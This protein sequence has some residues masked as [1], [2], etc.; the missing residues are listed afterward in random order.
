M[1]V[2]KANGKKEKFNFSKI[3]RTGIR[4]GVPKIDA[5]KIAKAVE[6]EAY[7]G[8]TTKEVLDM[9][10]AALDEKR[11]GY[12]SKYDL[13]GAIMRLG[14]SGFPFEKLVA[15]MFE[16]LGYSAVTDVIVRG[17]CVPHEVDVIAEKEG[18]R[19][20]IECKYRNFPGVYIGLQKALYVWARYEDLQA[21][22][23]MKKCE[24]FDVPY[25]ICN[26]R[27]SEQAMQYAS[28][29]GLKLKGWNYP[30]RESISDILTK[31]KIY[32]VTVLRSVNARTLQ[33]LS[34]ARM[35]LCDDLIEKKLIKTGISRNRAKRIMNEVAGVL[36]NN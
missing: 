10:L 18:M 3:V 31:N 13:K 21:G 26:T 33:L 12:A 20:M 6:E 8:I 29:I 23:K 11:V 32:P 19:A 28:C 30:P 16:R 25:L 4:A 1:Y 15:E 27:F 9:I 2:I 34:D 17:R 7:D 36:E 35:M 14:P 5:E 24:K 22:H